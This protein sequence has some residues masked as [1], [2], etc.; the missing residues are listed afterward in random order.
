MSHSHHPMRASL[1]LIGAVGAATV[2]IAL[3]GLLAGTGA[4]ANVSAGPVA[5]PT[6]VTIPAN[7]DAYVD[8]GKPDSNFGDADNLYVSLYGSP[9]IIQQTLA[10]FSL[11]AIPSGATIDDARFEMYLNTASGLADCQPEPGPQRVGLGGEGRQIRN[12]PGCLSLEADSV[13]RHHEGLARLG[14]D[15]PGRRLDQWRT[16]ELRRVCYRAGLRQP[17]HAALHQQRRGHGAAA[18][19]EVLS[20]DT[21]THGDQDPHADPNADRQPGHPH[22]QQLPR[23]PERTTP[24][25]TPTPR[26]PHAD[27]NATLHADAD[28][29]TPTHTPTRTGRQQRPLLRRHRTRTW[30]PVSP[31]PTRTA[32]PIG[33]APVLSLLPAQGGPGVAVQ[34]AGLRFPAGQTIT[35]YWDT[36]TPANRLGQVVADVRGAFQASIAVPAAASPG[37]HDIIAHYAGALLA[38]CTRALPGADIADDQIVPGRGPRGTRIAVALSGLN[39]NGAVTLYWDAERLLGPIPLAGATT[40]QGAVT[41]PLSASTGAHMVYAVNT[42]PRPAHHPCRRLV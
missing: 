32:T 18:G 22:Q 16:S 24:T 1:A 23:R 29:C 15:S 34:T 7:A 2:V 10:Q 38:E 3:F 26:H 42:D 30:T 12:R 33:G 35:L 40:W 41:V 6:V 31:T 4:D 28:T 27:P 25:Q 39:G 8:S 17:L 20:A 5:V 11:A 19:G 21:D 14:C 13:R 36:V 37:G 9:P